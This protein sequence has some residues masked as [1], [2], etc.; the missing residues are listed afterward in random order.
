MAKWFCSSDPAEGQISEKDYN[1]RRIIESVL[2][3]YTKDMEN[4]GY[5]GCN[6]GVS[7]N[8]YEDIAEDVMTELELW[9]EDKDGL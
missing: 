9:E 5:Y 7:E 1:V 4:Y 6:M 8:D 3:R 2:E